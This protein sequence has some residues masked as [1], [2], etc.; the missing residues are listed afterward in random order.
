MQTLPRILKFPKQKN[1]NKGI[2]PL[3]LHDTHN[4]AVP[5]H[6]SHH[7]PF[8]LILLYKYLFLFYLLHNISNH[9]A[10][11]QQQIH[12][13]TYT[14]TS[15]KPIAKLFNKL[16]LDEPAAP[17]CATIFVAA[18][19]V[20]PTPFANDNKKQLRWQQEQLQQQR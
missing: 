7:Q 5:W 15:E 4:A 13:Y 9:L 16:L 1:V 18:A 20:I 19:I 12:T 6:P 10:R 11:A 14:T 3:H 2:F 8:Y 17:V